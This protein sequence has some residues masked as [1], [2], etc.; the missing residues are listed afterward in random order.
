MEFDAPQIGQKV[1]EMIGRLDT[2]NRCSPGCQAQ[3]G[4]V[5]NNGR[6]W[7]VTIVEIGGR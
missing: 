6:Q 3:F 4:I 1:I 2:A 5:S 7:R